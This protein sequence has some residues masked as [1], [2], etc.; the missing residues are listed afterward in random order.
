[1]KQQLRNLFTKSIDNT[2]INW[3]LTLILFI[4]FLPSCSSTP[5]EY[6]KYKKIEGATIYISKQIPDSVFIPILLQVD[7]SNFPMSGSEW[8]LS[9][10]NDTFKLEFVCD[11][12]NVLQSQQTIIEFNSFEGYLNQMNIFSKYIM[13]GFVDEYFQKHLS[14]PK[15]EVKFFK[16]PYYGLKKY[17]FNEKHNI[18]FN[19]SITTQQL[20]KIAS[21]LKRLIYYFPQNK[22]FDFFFIKQ[23]EKY[24]F[25]L[26]IFKYNW[27]NVH[28]LNSI[29]SIVKSIEYLKIAN[30]IK[31]VMID[32]CTFEEKQLDTTNNR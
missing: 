20:E 6:K 10:E 8:Y 29:Y 21:V 1:M 32:N 11:I 17:T 24:Y 25:K 28:T 2:L 14:V 5:Q 23:N 12:N 22:Y 26:F 15:V 31:I 7:K 3:I 9:I 27:D 30:Q 4:A 18:Y 16:S 19:D 13:L